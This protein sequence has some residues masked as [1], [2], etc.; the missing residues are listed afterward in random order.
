ME[1]VQYLETIRISSKDVLW[2]KRFA[3]GDFVYIDQLR[4]IIKSVI[5]QFEEEPLTHV[6]LFCKCGCGKKIEQPKT[7]RK[8]VFFNDLCRLHFFRKSEQYQKQKESEFFEN[9]LK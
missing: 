4:T 9:I 3:N 8:K 1:D 5:N 7:G 6:Q 2:L